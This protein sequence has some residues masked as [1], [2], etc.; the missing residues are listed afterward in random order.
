MVFGKKKKKSYLPATESW[1]QLLILRGS[2]RFEAIF[3][4]LYDCFETLST[5]TNRKSWVCPRESCDFLC[6]RLNPKRAQNSKKK[7][8]NHT[9]PIITTWLEPRIYKRQERPMRIAV[10]VYR[11][12]LN[13]RFSRIPACVIS[14]TMFVL[15]VHSVDSEQPIS[16]EDEESGFSFAPSRRSQ[17]PDKLVPSLKLTE[18]KG[19]IHLYRNSSHSSLPNPSSRSTTLFVV[20]VPNYLSSLDFIRFCDSQI[21]HVSQILFIRWVVTLQE[22]RK[23]K[24]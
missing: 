11:P 24:G 17:R 16:I 21:E 20:A 23:K 14:E 4:G 5:A 6:V 13:H 9:R 22:L 15:R 8:I 19:L 3:S 12:S 2:E 10:T 7:P 1:N 18:R